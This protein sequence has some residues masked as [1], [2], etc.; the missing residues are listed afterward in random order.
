MGTGRPGNTRN[1]CLPTT[2]ISQK[3]CEFYFVASYYPMFVVNYL[4]SQPG[5]YYVLEIGVCMVLLK[6]LMLRLL[7][8]CRRGWMGL[9]IIVDLTNI[10][11][12]IN[13]HKCMQ[14]VLYLQYPWLT[15]PGVGG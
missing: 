10:D 11:I 3:R 5:L 8:S 12:Y 13:L 14:P 7:H 15:K 9:N 1:P 4:L 2:Y 6:I